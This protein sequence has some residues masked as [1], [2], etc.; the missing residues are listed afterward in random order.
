MQQYVQGDIQYICAWGAVHM[1]CMYDNLYSPTAQSCSIAS[2]LH[3]RSLPVLLDNE[4][5]LSGPNPN[6]HI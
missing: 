2:R 3:C 5:R 4:Q 6:S 1:L